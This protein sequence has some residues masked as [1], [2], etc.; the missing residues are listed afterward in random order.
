MI[1][2][3][4]THPAV[5]K[6]N[7]L[8]Y[9]WYLLSRT[10]GNLPVSRYFVIITTMSGKLDHCSWFSSCCWQMFIFIWI[11][12]SLA[13]PFAYPVNYFSSHFLHFQVCKPLNISLD[14]Q[15]LNLYKQYLQKKLWICQV[16][17]CYLYLNVFFFLLFR[18]HIHVSSISQS[19]FQ[20]NKIIL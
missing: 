16:L 12:I 6:R 1:V 8:S 5:T 20:N 15:W 18:K 7:V 9:P 2:A 19:Y 3:T 10:N 17:N 14:V 11:R 13:V 4:G